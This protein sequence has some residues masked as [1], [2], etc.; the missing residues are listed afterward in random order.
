MNSSQLPASREWL[1]PDGLGGFASG[2]STGI[3]T[4]RYHALLLTA[5]SPPAGRMVLVNG[6]DAWIETP[7]GRFD[8][9]S[10][11]YAPDVIGGGGAQ[12]VQ[13]FTADPWPRWVF[14]FEDGT[15][16]EQEILVARESQ[17]TQIC[18]RL[19][20]QCKSVRLFVRPFLS[21]RDYHSL[22]KENP[23]FRFDAAVNGQRVV[24]TPYPGVP[25]VVALSNGYYQHEPHWYRNFRY[26]EETARGLDDTEDLPAPG[27]FGFD[28]VSEYS[29]FIFTT[30][31]SPALSRKRHLS[32]LRFAEAV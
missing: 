19:L 21:G 14:S 27:V 30:A 2:T 4:R 10:Q 29:V 11:H 15:R 22:H 32:T 3:R 25:A 13:Q 26:A 24:W 31:D 16:I 20:G 12:R 23:A 18:W 1:E 5:T 9:S 6:F 17:L 7:A 28:S 8:L